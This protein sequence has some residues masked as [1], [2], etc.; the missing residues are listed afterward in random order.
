MFP[1]AEAVGSAAG[2]ISLSPEAALLATSARL[3]MGWE[4]VVAGGIALAESPVVVPLLIVG[5]GFMFAWSMNHLPKSEE[6]MVSV[7][8]RRLHAEVA[9]AQSKFK[10]QPGKA[11]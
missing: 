2:F 7:E 4:S 11:G 3:A 8:Y 5:L 1:E 9:Y 10:F 6:P